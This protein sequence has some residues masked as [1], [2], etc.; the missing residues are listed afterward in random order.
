MASPADGAVDVSHV[1]KL[2]RA[3]CKHVT[4]FHHARAVELL[5]RAIVAAETLRQPDCLIV[6]RLHNLRWAEVRRMIASALPKDDV[7]TADLATHEYV[8]TLSTELPGILDVLERRRADGTLL[9]GCCRAHEAVWFED[10]TRDD[11]PASHVSLLDETSFG[12]FV[13]IDTYFAA[14]CTAVTA[15]HM[16]VSVPADNARE[17]LRDP[18]LIVIE[19]ALRWT[20]QCAGCAKVRVR[21]G[22]GEWRSVVSQLPAE[23]RFLENFR[24]ALLPNLRPEGLRAGPIL[25]VWRNIEARGL[26]QIMRTERIHTCLIADRTMRREEQAAKDA[27][28]PLRACALP[29]C[30][31]REAHV[32]HFKRCGACGAVVY[33]SKAHQA[34]HWPAHKAA[35]KAAR[36]AASQAAAE[37]G[38]SQDA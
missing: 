19:H 17:Q 15:L 32:G 38:A 14:A 12:L 30:G 4:E 21:P 28:V 22:H 36:K 11:C 6:A 31:A 25:A 35:C 1:C 24:T 29:S 16:S 5:E 2:T 27:G 20:L 18:C 37:G 7:A 10:F 9:K 8:N 13:G 33:C 26:L 3:A 23:G 34:E